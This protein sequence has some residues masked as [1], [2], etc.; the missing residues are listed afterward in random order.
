[1][2]TVPI[3]DQANLVVLRERLRR[4]SDN[5][6]KAYGRSVLKECR[7]ADKRTEPLLPFEIVLNEAHAE[8]RSRRPAGPKALSFGSN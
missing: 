2:T 4:M 1:M 7:P 6:L 8:W 5:D 3:Y